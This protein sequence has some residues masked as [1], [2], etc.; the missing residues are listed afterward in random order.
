MTISQLCS[1]NFVSHL[2]WELNSQCTLLQ[3]GHIFQ[4]SSSSERSGRVWHVLY[5]GCSLWHKKKEEITG[6]ID[7]VSR[8][9]IEFKLETFLYMPSVAIKFYT[10]LTKRHFQQ[11]FCHSL[12]FQKHILYFHVGTKS[13]QPQDKKTTKLGIKQEIYPKQSPNKNR[14]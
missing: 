9:G 12:L 6:S 4:C 5:G 11:Q 3:V 8:F 14:L 7:K 10:C 13:D 1:P 2:P